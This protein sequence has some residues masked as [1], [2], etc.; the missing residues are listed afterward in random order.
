M[1][2]LSP[3]FGTLVSI[4]DDDASVLRALRRM[5]ESAGF[6]VETFVSGQELLRHGILARPACIVIDVHL[7]DMNGFQLHRRLVADGHTIPVIFVTAH[8]DAAT[9]A[10]AERAGCVAYLPKPVDGEVLLGAIRRA[11]GGGPPEAH[12]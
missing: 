4:V 3:S 5:V 11:V 1:A 7:G 9:E 2:R 12:S 10:C 8:D 6:T